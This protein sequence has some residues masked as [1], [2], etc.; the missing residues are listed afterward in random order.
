[1]L[2]MVLIFVFVFYGYGDHRDLHVL[3]HSFP[4]RRSSDLDERLARPLLAALAA[5]GDLVVGENQPYSARNGHG[6]SLD[7]HGA[8][9]GLPHVELE[10]DRKSTRLN[11]SH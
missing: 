5:R 4:T 1:M 8:A 6:Y 10:I 11:S 9:R 2:C 7:Q 3:T